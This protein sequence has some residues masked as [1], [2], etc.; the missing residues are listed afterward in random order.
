[1]GSG[2][3]QTGTLHRRTAV[4]RDHVERIIPVNSSR[5]C[6]RISLG[7]LDHDTSTLPPSTPTT[8][9][10]V[11]FPDVILVEKATPEPERCFKIFIF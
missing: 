3:G 5:L 6:E 9:P 4:L 8:T 11:F 2:L 1:M 7:A 10:L